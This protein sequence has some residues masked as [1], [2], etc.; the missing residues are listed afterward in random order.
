MNQNSGHK[1]F[2]TSPLKVR[3]LETD[4]QSDRE[5]SLKKLQYQFAGVKKAISKH[6]SEKQ[7]VDQL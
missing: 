3:Q 2:T 7:Q 5:T 1:Q 4:K 6:Q